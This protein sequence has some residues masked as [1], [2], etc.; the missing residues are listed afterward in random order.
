[1][2]IFK[3]F[4]LIILLTIGA[5]AQSAAR[6]EGTVA[7]KSDAYNPVTGNLKQSVRNLTVTLMSKTDNKTVAETKTGERGEFVFENVAA[8]DYYLFVACAYCWRGEVREEIAVA[9]GQTLKIRIELQKVTVSETVTVSADVRQ[10]VEQVAKTVNVIDAQEMRS[11][12]DF[13]LVE[14][15]KTIPGF[16]VAQLGG[17]GRT[18]NVK[19]RGLRN[20]DTAVLIDGIRFR[21]ASAIS[22]DAS[23]FLSDF[24][25]TNVDRIEV[26]RGSGSSLYGTNAIGGVID[27]QTPKPQNGFHGQFGG[28]L[29]GLGLGR[30]RGNL[31]GGNDKF[32][33]TGGLSRTVYTKGVDGDDDARNTNFQA[34]AEYNPFAKTNLSARFFVSDAFVRLNTDPDTFGAL[35]AD[36]TTVIDARPGVSFTPDTD[37]P[38]DFQRSKFFNGQLVATQA[39]G[40]NIVVQGYYS[41]LKTSRRNTNGP[42]GGGFQPFGGDETYLYDGQIHTINAHLNW[43]AKNNQLTGG[44]EYEWEKFANRGVFTSAASNFATSARQSSRTV[45]VQDLVGFFANRLQLSGAFRAEWFALRAPTFSSA[46]FPNRFNNPS[47]PPASYTGDATVSY[48]FARTGTK[49]RVHAGN[50]Y[51]VPSLYERFGT[52]YFFSSF[53]GLGN[54]AL[55]PERSVAVDAAIEQN[56]LKNRV[57]LSATYFYTKIDDEVAY[58]PTDDLGAAAYY[59]YD[60]HFARG[61]ETSARVRPTATTDV[62]ASY[63]FTNS[64]VRNYS[65][66]TLM[67]PLTTVGRDRPAFGVPAHQFT[68]VA[69]QRFKRAWLNLDLLA[70]GRYLAPI[71]SNT[72]FQSYVYRFRGSRKADLTAGY[73]FGFRKDKMTLRIYGTL[74]NLFDDEYYESG[75]R[76]AGRTGRVGLSFGF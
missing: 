23:P 1:M 43:T 20:Q 55:K 35:P 73:T 76:T 64:D 49:L 36:N 50:G 46:S 34:R 11:R 54:P 44:F 62:F 42:L 56:L 3:V 13:S 6:I 65:R 22:G 67:P 7:Q 57:R 15:L 47:V 19:T 14:S 51:R 4:G 69:N 29:G 30:F 16:R 74:E 68:L 40:A 28:A 32:G 53:F 59:N 52:Y 75:F 33:F 72:S 70:T 39:L 2:R 9:A 63:T 8:G 37:D 66:V 41:G 21:D 5:G 26:L 61:V 71:F 27:F 45:Y 60:K 25:L 12:A 48:Y 24:T 31:S 17:F 10:P 18:A 58:L 38:D